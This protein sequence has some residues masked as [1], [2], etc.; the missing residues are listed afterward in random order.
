MKTYR[1]KQRVEE[2]LTTVK[3]QRNLSRKTLKA[4]RLDLEQFGKFAEEHG[5]D[6]VGR[7]DIESYIGFL[8]GTCKPSTVRRKMAVLRTFFGFMEDEFGEENP[9]MRMRLKLK[10][11][12]RIPRAVPLDTMGT[13]FSSVYKRL[14]VYERG[15][16]RY[17]EALR[18]IAV[19]EALFATGMRVSELCDLR[20]DDINVVSGIVYITGKGDK[21]RIG[22]LC[23]KETL[24]ALWE[25]SMVFIEDIRRSGFFFINRNRVHL[26]PDSVRAMIKR[27]AKEAG[28]DMLITPHMFRHTFAT[29]LLESD[30]DIRIIQ[31]FLGHSS[32]VTT[33]IYT[34]ISSAKHRTVLLEK[35]PRSRLRVSGG[36]DGAVSDPSI[37]CPPS[38]VDAG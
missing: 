28:I 16:A 31:H 38:V 20:S 13:L 7:R 14:A 2:F 6:C 29:Q 12:N 27:R 26:S 17:N 11:P 24:R 33:Q 18:D 25:Y 35:N 32:I 23:A 8:R 21:R 36:F 5:K 9:F 37:P 4:Y 3:A 30:V 19:L 22:Q 15:S 1:W 34:H 10:E